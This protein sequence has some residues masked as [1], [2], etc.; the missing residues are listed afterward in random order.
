MSGQEIKLWKLLKIKMTRYIASFFMVFCFTVDAYA[1]TISKIQIDGNKRISEETIKVYGDINIGKDYNEEDINTI[2]RKLYETEFFEKIELNLDNKIL[3]INVK[4]HPI[5]NKLI[6]TGEQSNKYKEE[7]KKIIK[8]KEKNSYIK[9]YLSD[10][11]NTIKL[12]YSS[13]GYNFVEVE[14]KINKINEDAYDL[15]IEINRGEKTKITSIE[16]IGNNKIRSN[17]LR[18]IIASEE[19]KFWKILTKNTNFSKDLINLDIRL[20]K[21]YYK[22]LGFY[23]VKINSNSAQ[24]NNEKNINLI[25]SIEEGVRY[26]INKISINSDSVFDKK[27]FFPLE[28]DYR[29]YVGDYYSPFKIKK[30]LE[31]LDDLIENNS[32]QFVEHN[33]EEIIEKDSINIVFN[34]FEGEK[35]LIERVNITGNNITNEDVIRGELIIDEGDPFT[36]LGLE[37][38][39]AEI[40]ARNIFKDVKYNVK[41]GSKNNL[42]I[43]DIEVEEKPTGEISAG[44]GIGTNGGSFAINVKESNWM[45]RGQSLTFEIEVDAE[46]LGGALIFSDPNY[47]FLGNSIDYSISSEN[48]DKPDQGYE[49]TVTSLGIGTSFEQYQDL[50]VNLGL[51]A[52]YDDLRTDNSATDALKKQSGSFTELAGNYNFSFDKRNRVFNPTDGSLLTI[53]QSLPFYADKSFVSNYLSFNNYKTLNENAIGSSKFLLSTINGLGS[54]NVRL[55]KRKS[56]SNRRMRGF[57]RNK[58]GPVDGSDHIGGNYAAVLNLETNLPN[59]LPDDTRTDVILFLDFGNVWGVDYDSQ[60]DDS[61]KIRSS[62]GAMASWI[63]P[64]GPMTFTLSQ[65]LTKASSDKTESF[66]FSLGTTF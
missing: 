12:L 56:L 1:E 31:K 50:R 9:S 35:I 49:N 58:I 51:E 15:L 25:Y 3:V 41:N 39:V 46:S 48:N 34:I 61:N 45:G 52:S 40:K 54:D 32:L 66:N 53:G 22:S 30:L 6:I 59:L 29:K 8:L 4:E 36:K 13:L 7:I 26:T 20:L 60:I 63:S 10:D 17:R 47:D 11:T 16:F 43:I 55:S 42:K 37:K 28:K 65:N 38:S 19:T 2:L 5:I 23:D 21:N 24:I 14:T 44:A 33:V 57:E 64:L 62:T 27:I 18:D